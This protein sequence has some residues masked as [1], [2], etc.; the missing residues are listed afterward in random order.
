[1]LALRRTAFQV[2]CLSLKGIAWGRSLSV[3]DFANDRITDTIVDMNEDENSLSRER[4]GGDDSVAV[5]REE[6]RG[7]VHE[8]ANEFA[9]NESY[10]LGY[11]HVSGGN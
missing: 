11:L 4:L 3:T 10:S 9:R 7:V 8:Y 1:M 5:V 6:E 2:S